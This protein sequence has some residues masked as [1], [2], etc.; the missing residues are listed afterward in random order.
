MKF[1]IKC[2]IQFSCLKIRSVKDFK[3]KDETL[4]ERHLLTRIKL[5]ICESEYISLALSYT[6]FSRIA[7]DSNGNKECYPNP[8]IKSI[9][10]YQ[11]DQV[12]SEYCAKM[13]HSVMITY[14]MT[15][16]KELVKLF[17]KITQT[18]MTSTHV[19]ARTILIFFNLKST[20]TSTIYNIQA[21]SG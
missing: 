10:F 18:T 1:L 9:I 5:S 13:Q 2:E 6:G 3:R 7:T 19:I 17:M 8:V 14:L 15:S 4:C 11:H 12:L 20:L 16:V 21:K